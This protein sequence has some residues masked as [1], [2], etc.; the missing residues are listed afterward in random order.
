MGKDSALQAYRDLIGG[1]FDSV[2]LLSSWG[3][4]AHSRVHWGLVGRL[5]KSTD[6]PSTAWGISIP[7]LALNPKP[8]TAATLP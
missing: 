8:D 2:S 4:G 3:Y 7:N 5:T 6:Y 1:F